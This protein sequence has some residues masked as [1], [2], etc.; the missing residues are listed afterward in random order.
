MLNASAVLYG[1]ALVLPAKE[2]KCSSAVPLRLI[3][4]DVST[5]ESLSK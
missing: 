1:S 5:E 2:P 3:Y 4:E